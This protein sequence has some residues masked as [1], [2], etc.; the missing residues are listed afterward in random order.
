MAWRPTDGVTVPWGLVL[1]LLSAVSLP[2]VARLYSRV[3]G[4]G[5]AAGWIVGLG[6]LLEK[7]PGGDFLL[8]A[9]WLGQVFLY[10]GAILVVVTAAWGGK[11]AGR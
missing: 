1:A 6:L 3:A 5:A 10:G 11:G 4:G 2:L 9:D 7:G 8:A